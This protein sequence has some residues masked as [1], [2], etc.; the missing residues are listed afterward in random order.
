[1]RGESMM[2]VKKIANFNNR[3]KIDKS[4]VIK[5]VD[6]SVGYVFTENGYAGY[7]KGDVRA[8][9][10]A[11]G[12]FFKKLPEKLEVIWIDEGINESMKIEGCKFLSK[13][14]TDSYANL[15]CLYQ[16]LIYRDDAD[17]DGEMVRDLFRRVYELAKKDIDYDPSIGAEGY[18]GIIYIPSD[19]VSREFARHISR[20]FG[21]SAAQFSSPREFCEDLKIKCLDM[22]AGDPFLMN[23]CIH[24]VSMRFDLD[25]QSSERIIR[26][27]AEIQEEIEGM[28]VDVE[29]GEVK[30]QFQ[31][32]MSQLEAKAE[33][34]KLRIEAEKKKVRA[35]S[36]M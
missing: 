35:A 29:S 26:K 32:A 36:G 2:F 8:S 20:S 28:Q 19:Y 4:T 7:T 1:M 9:D 6:G 11:T 5:G 16:I 18:H 25:L 22:A 30:L 31:L 15:E 3:A 33:K 13:D 27:R 24:V 21:S 17:F 34:E 12:G 14:F 10:Y 23:Y